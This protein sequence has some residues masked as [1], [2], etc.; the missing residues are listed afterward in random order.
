MTFCYTMKLESEKGV[1]R[2]LYYPRIQVTESEVE[3]NF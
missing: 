1:Q 2:N 3:A